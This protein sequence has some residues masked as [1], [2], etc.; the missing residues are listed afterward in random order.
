MHKRKRTKKK[1]RL[2]SIKV[3]REGTMVKP[4]LSVLIS[5]LG[6]VMVLGCNSAKQEDDLPGMLRLR[7]DGLP[8]YKNGV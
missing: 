7:V 1:S 6:L 5:L 4:K 2:E 3:L 8:K